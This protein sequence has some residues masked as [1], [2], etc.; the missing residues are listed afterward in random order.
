MFWRRRR[1]RGNDE[2]DGAGWIQRSMGV[3]GKGCGVFFSYGG[4]S[5]ERVNV[6]GEMR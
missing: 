2:V 1:R 4:F 6:V 3:S 5:T